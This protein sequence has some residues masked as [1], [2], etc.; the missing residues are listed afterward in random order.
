MTGEAVPVHRYQI[1]SWSTNSTSLLCHASNPEIMSASAP[2]SIVVE[3]YLRSSSA[4]CIRHRAL[5]HVDFTFV[6]S[7]CSIETIL[8]AG[9]TGDFLPAGQA[10][11]LRI[12]IGFEHRF[13]RLSGKFHSPQFRQRRYQ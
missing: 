4:F 7:S 12:L 8:D 3:K 5:S 13:L 1:S 2:L 11:K 9:R 6:Q 10:L